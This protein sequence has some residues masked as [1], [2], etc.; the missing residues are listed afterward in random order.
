MHCSQEIA[1]LLAKKRMVPG[2]ES[3]VSP[4]AVFSSDSRFLL[5]DARWLSKLRSFLIT[6]LL[7]FTWEQ[8]R[9]R[10]SATKLKTLAELDAALQVSLST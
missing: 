1:K 5:C 4:L 9:A 2:E 10:L 8:W 3:Q 6:F 7:W